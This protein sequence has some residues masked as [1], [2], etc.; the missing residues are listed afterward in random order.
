MIAKG[1][2]ALTVIATGQGVVVLAIETRELLA[3]ST[4]GISEASV[5]AIDVAP[6]KRMD[7]ITDIP[8]PSANERGTARLAPA[9]IV[10]QSLVETA[11]GQRLRTTIEWAAAEDGRT[12]E[13]AE[14][15]QRSIGRFPLLETNDWRWNCL[16]LG[17]LVLTSVNMRIS[18]SRLL[19]ITYLHTSHP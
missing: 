7:E 11:V 9:M 19:E 10:G 14:E 8:I 2:E 1:I 6:L 15:T 17:I 3:M 12:T 13:M 4:L 5:G 18:Q 16:V